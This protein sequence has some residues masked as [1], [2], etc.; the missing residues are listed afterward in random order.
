MRSSLGGELLLISWGLRGHPASG[1]RA[2]GGKFEHKTH[3]KLVRKA[4]EFS[5]AKQAT[6][7][8]ASKNQDISNPRLEH[9][10]KDR[11][12]ERLR[13]S[14]HRG[15]AQPRTRRAGCLYR[16]TPEKTRGGG[17]EK[18]RTANGCRI[19][20]AFRCVNFLRPSF[21]AAER[22]EDRG[23][24]ARERQAHVH[25]LSHLLRVGNVGGERVVFQRR[26]DVSQVSAVGGEE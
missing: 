10:I 25:T 21:F 9:G 11:A 17:R 6:R 3:E 23:K 2:R 26:L 19:G 18:R 15:P 1:E 16:Y 7:R 4:G 20:L 22:T 13:G 12:R 5:P 14:F 24:E 8:E